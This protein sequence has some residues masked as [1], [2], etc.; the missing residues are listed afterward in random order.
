MLELSDNFAKDIQSNQTYL[1][2]L[3][4]L[5]DSIYISTNDV[6]MEQTFA[7]IVKN[8]S[9]INE[10][11]DFFDK[12]F[13]TSNVTIDLIN[14]EINN[15]IISSLLFNPSVLNK[16]VKIYLKSQSCETL[17]DCLFVYEGITK[18]ILEN[19]DIVSLEI[20]DKSN[21]LINESLPRRF[22]SDTLED[23]YSNKPIPLVYGASVLAPAVYEKNTISTDYEKLIVDDNFIKKAKEPK[24]FVDDTYLGIKLECSKFLDI[25]SD[26]IYQNIKAQQWTIVGDELFIER[27]IE[28]PEDYSDED[29]SFY[30]ASLPAF[31]F[32]EISVSPKLNFLPST[33]KL[34]YTLEGTSDIRNATAQIEVFENLDTN[35]KVTDFSRAVYEEEKEV[36]LDVRNYGDI[37]N[38]FSEPQLWA[39]GG[40][41]RL[42][43]IEANG[44][45]FASGSNIINF[46]ME[47][48]P[49]K[50][51]FLSEVQK[52]DGNVIN[53]EN[54]FIL[55]FGYE[56]SIIP[57]QEPQYNYQGTI[58]RRPKIA[59]Q[60][61]TGKASDKIVDLNDLEP[62]SIDGNVEIFE[63]NNLVSVPMEDIESTNLSLGQK[64]RN[65]DGSGTNFQTLLQNGSINYIKIRWLNAAK[66]A[67]LTDYKNYPIYLVVDGRV[68]DVAGTFTGISETQV[69]Y[70]QSENPVVNVSSSTGGGY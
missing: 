63:H 51:K 32:L 64:V 16:S 14:T 17:D 68:D 41:T 66:T 18:N 31:G 56:I 19:K 61:G 5:N 25:T 65:V 2:H 55:N 24:I 33:H 13:Q 11:I 22:T 52:L 9:N 6:R 36:F 54:E 26:T 59:F 49:N 34:R 23:K 38:L 20:E 69:Q 53:F 60:A 10:S 47:S 43:D 42:N 44:Y 28:L 37:P 50:S 8:I 46:E 29:A 70:N 40:I 3:V 21:F 27:Q 57:R 7:P 39:W 1:L 45:S 62:T 15:E 67:V 35:N 4:V 12:Q 30:R 48:M 58:I